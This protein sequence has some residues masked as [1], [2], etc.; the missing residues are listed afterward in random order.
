MA[1]KKVTIGKKTTIKKVGGSPEIKKSMAY[2]KFIEEANSDYS[3]L[4]SLDK[5]LDSDAIIDYEKCSNDIQSITDNS[6]KLLKANFNINRDF[7]QAYIMGVEK[8]YNKLVEKITM[9]KR[10]AK[11]RTIHEANI[12]YT[13]SS[14]QYKKTKETTTS[15]VGLHPIATINALNT[16]KRRLGEIDGAS[17]S[18]LNRSRV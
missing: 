1:P 4:D 16:L 11:K 10:L 17:S 9:K 14:S 7:I 5:I 2:Y 8:I 13:L 3:K 6:I 12:G 18:K 15:V